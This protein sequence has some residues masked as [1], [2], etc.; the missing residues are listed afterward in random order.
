MRGV[1]SVF[2]H[3]VTQVYSKNSLCVHFE[4]VVVGT[5]RVR[6][7]TYT[8]QEAQM[9]DFPSCF[10]LN[11]VNEIYW[12]FCFCSSFMRTSSRFGCQTPEMHDSE[13]GVKIF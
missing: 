6:L 3:C 11:V 10:F 12:K 13:S 9:S 8:P 5:N 4:F 7:R 1:L 2:P